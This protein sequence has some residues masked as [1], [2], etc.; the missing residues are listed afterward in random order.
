MN[1]Y[2]VVLDNKVIDVLEDA[3]WVKLNRR[4]RIVLC[5]PAEALGVV[6][7]DGKTTWNLDSTSGLAGFD[8]S[9]VTVVDITE[10][11]ATEL[12]TLLGLGGEVTN[13]PSGS[14]VEFPSE[15]ETPDEP[16]T[17]GT[18][19]EVKKRC[20][21]K[22]SSVCQQTIFD[23]FDVTLSNGEEK[24]FT[25][26]VEDQLNLLSLSTLLATGVESIP[27]HADGELCEYY[28]A[29]DMTLIMTQA[30]QFKTYHTS[31][32]NSLKNWVESMNSIAE[33]G[34]VAYG[35]AIPSEFCSVVLNQLVLA[36]EVG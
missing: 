6:S 1:Y 9:P 29:A 15:P 27:Y 4:G 25:L 21:E 2:K 20:L 28:S 19:E 5:E 32:Y 14:E 23:G 17:D 36:Q 26:K 7:S 10:E 30:T 8:Y 16:I 11:E 22:L 31:Y 18:L 3:S 24:H 13:T 34:S 12:K 35:D 33:V